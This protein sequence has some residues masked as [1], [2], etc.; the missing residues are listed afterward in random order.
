MPDLRCVLAMKDSTKSFWLLWYAASCVL[1]LLVVFKQAREL[2]NCRESRRQLSLLIGD[3][4]VVGER[5]ISVCEDARVVFVPELEP[6]RCVLVGE[7]EEAS[8]F[9]MG[10]SE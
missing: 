6:N 2:E 4:V 10:G 5:L 8:T 9:R 3:A 1:L 7:E